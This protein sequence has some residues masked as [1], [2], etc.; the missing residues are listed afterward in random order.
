MSHVKIDDLFERIEKEEMLDSSWEEMDTDAWTDEKKE[1]VLNKIYRKMQAEEAKSLEL[2][3]EKE[4]KVQQPLELE[5]EKESKV[6]QKLNSEEKLKLGKRIKKRRLAFLLAAVL[7]FSILTA[8]AWENEWDILLGQYVGLEPEAAVQVAGGSIS[9]EESDT[10]SGMTVTAVSAIGDQNSQYIRIDTDYPCDLVAQDGTEQACYLFDKISILIHDRKSDSGV[11]KSFASVMMPFNNEGKLSFWLELVNCSGINR[12]YITVNVQDLY[13]L[14]TD[15]EYE[16]D[17]LLVEGS[18]TL[19]WKNY[20]R[21]DSR[22]YYPLKNVGD[23]EFDCLLTSVEITPISIR[24][25]GYGYSRENQDFSV[26]KIVMEDGTVYELDSENG[27]SVSN[28]FER[29][30]YVTIRQ[31]GE[32]LDPKQ[33]RSVFVRGQEIIF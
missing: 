9:I 19:E 27:G 2:E 18:W 23:E 10:Q 15:G 6:Q 30:S 1:R 20:Y 26:E 14:T 5:S 4:S 8:F 33:V 12:D 32:V 24:L 29:E 11:T 22:K 28:N 3:S 7:T 17:Q 25:H 16:Q 21:V 31:I 13:G